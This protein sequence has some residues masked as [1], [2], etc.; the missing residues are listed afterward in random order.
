MKK[1]MILMV[2]VVSLALAGTALAAD[3]LQKAAEDITEA[4]LVGP[5]SI[6]VHK[7]GDIQMSF[8]A[9][10]R[11]IP[12]SESNYDF[13][14]SDEIGGMDLFQNH[15]NEAGW[16]NN[17]YIRT[18][19]K[20]YFNAMPNDQVW[21]FYGALEFDS[22]TDTSVVDDRGQNDTGNSNYGLERLH[23]TVKL[24]FADSLNLR[25]HA[26]W[27]IY[28]LD[29][30]D[31]A[32]LIYGDDNPGFWITGNIGEQADFQVGYHKLQEND[33]KAS[34]L[35]AGNYDDDRDLY[36]ASLDYHIN[37]TNHVKFM[38]AF[39]RIRNIA[40]TTVQGYLF[41]SNID[42]SL[43]SSQSAINAGQNDLSSS[44]YSIGSVLA[45]DLV[46][47]G[48]VTGTVVD[49]AA[50]PV[51]FV[52]EGG[53]VDTAVVTANSALID[54][55]IGLGTAA[56][57]VGTQ[58]YISTSQATLDAQQQYIYNNYL[59]TNTTQAKTD[60]HHLGF[61]YQGDFG[62]LKPFVEAV[63]QFGSA[64]D[65]GL[66]A[67]GYEEDYDIKAYALAA[68]LAFDLKDAIGFKFAP[69][70]G[71]MY[72]SGDDDPDDGDL[73]GYTG[74]ENAQRFSYHWG[75]ENT[76]IG[77]TNLLM[78]TVL[79]GFLP[80]FYGSGTPVAT[81]GLQNL[82]GTGAGRGD[83]PGLTMYSIGLDMAPKRFLLYR[84]NVNVMN[85]NED[86]R[87]PTMAGTVA[88]IDSGYAGTEWDNE[89][90]LALSKNMFIK[91]QFSFL[92]PGEV[93]EDITEAYSGE[94]CDDVAT[95]LGM[96]FIWNF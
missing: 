88:E 22:V 85:F 11:I 60:S 84:T 91:G 82:A 6:N 62:I 25:L 20:I 65:T 93:I 54:G 79:Y 13:G 27:D 7:A 47:G 64:D 56:T 18:E 78:G 55:A 70:I 14:L 75:G 12:T 8:G 38:Y 71:I 66:S 19:N 33:W 36:T 51:E 21:S 96:E 45:L 30:F 94:K 69:H 32:G 43:A 77:D 49:P 92:F 67:Y 15:A 16:V 39:D 46:N 17:A 58:A 2:L 48:T 34:D 87:L 41:G 28:H 73:E 52:V 86:F 42:A 80:E 10:V 90:T 61:Y 89:I 83:N 29:V 53:T 44:A 26:G 40:A 37:K 4:G 95:R 81:G 24:P 68:D 59:Y 31:G 5:G 57:L 9:T 35:S 23:C 74:V 72:T 3:D 50:L 76:I 1:W 63:Y